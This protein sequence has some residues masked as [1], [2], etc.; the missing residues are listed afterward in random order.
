MSLSLKID[1]ATHAAAKFAC[2]NWHYSK[3]L[4]PSK[5][6]KFGVWENSKFVGCV[7]F[8]VGVTNQL[9]KR[10]GLNPEEGCELIRVALKNHASSVSRILAICLRLLRKS[11]PK[12]QLVV[13]FADPFQGHHGGIYQA[14]NWIFDGN[15][16]TPDEFIFKGKRWHQRAF[17]HKYGHLRNHP[18]VQRVK[19]S[20]KHR[21]LMPLTDALR[22]KLAPLA[23]PYP[24]RAGSIVADAPA[25][26]AGE[27]GS[28]PTPAL[29]SQPDCG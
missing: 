18:S 13:S 7:V 25:I 16:S 15:T 10:Y 24:K 22:K 3:C 21:Y 8:G 14:G 20:K 27:G 19:G 17:N 29:H 26:H 2:E 23:K 4:P 5:N 1:W 11:F 6:A 28:I 9:V 12:L